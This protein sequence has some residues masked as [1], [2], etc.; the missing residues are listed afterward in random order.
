MKN[1]FHNLI[2]ALALAVFIFFFHS[3]PS[4]SNTLKFVQLSDVHYSTVRKD[5]SY[6]LLSQSK[7]LLLDAV[8]QINKLNDVNFVMETGDLIDQPTECSA[9]DAFSIMNTIKYP[10][11][12]AVG[13]HDTSPGGYLDKERF[14][15]LLREYNPAFTFDKLYYSFAPKKGFKVIVL[16][17]APDKGITSNGYIPEEELNWLDCELQDSKKDVVL[18]FL[19]FPLL[20]PFPSAHHRILNSDEFYKVLNKYKNPIAI[21]AGHYHT[22]KITK[23]NNIIH[24]ASPS[25]VTYPNSFRVVSVT[26]YRDKA[27]FD[28]YFYETQLK[29]LQ[30]KA[31]LMTFGSSSY[32]GKEEDRTTTVIIDK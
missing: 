31:R 23:V 3:Q 4:R 7:K 30:T 24:V 12:Y 6:K 11:Y 10:W 22:T 5:T 21:F 19:H 14:V 20:E 28:F 29:E 13:N 1:F 8:A 16:D 25:L 32:Y 9:I 2:V 26:N 27:I 17:G 15:E 18:I